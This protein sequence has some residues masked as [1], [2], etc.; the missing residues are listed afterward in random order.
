MTKTPGEVGV[1]RAEVATGVFSGLGVGLATPVVA[2]AGVGP[3]GVAW[4]QAAKRRSIKGSK[5][6]RRVIATSLRNDHILPLR[7]HVRQPPWRNRKAKQS[8]QIVWPSVPSSL[9]ANR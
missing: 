3:T 9:A 4:S 5:N 7:K 1:G 2:G 6:R 8:F